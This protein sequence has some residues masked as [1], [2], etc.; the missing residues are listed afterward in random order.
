MGNHQSCLRFSLEESVWF[1][2]GQEVA[3]LVSISLDPDIAIQENDQY[4]TIRGSLELT[5][6]YK[7][8]DGEEEQEQQED[9]L[10]IPPKT[11]H[12]V[13]RNVEDNMEFS[14]RFPVDITIPKNRIEN[15]YDL[16]IVVE[17]FDYDIPE[18]HLLTLTADL[19]ITGLYG[20]Q[21]H[22]GREE[23]IPSGEYEGASEIDGSREEEDLPVFEYENKELDD[24]PEPV[25]LEEYHDSHHSLFS[26]EERIYGGQKEAEELQEDNQISLPFSAEARKEPRQEEECINAEKMAEE[27]LNLLEQRKEKKVEIQEPADEQQA[28]EEEKKNEKADVGE[29]ETKP[30]LPLAN[31]PETGSEEE[32][33]EKKPEQ[34]E[35]M[36][37]LKK[38]KQEEES[39]SSSEEDVQQEAAKK[40]SKKK[41]LSIA[42]FLAR[43]EEAEIAKIRVCIVQHGDTV[44]GLADRYEVSIQHLLRA[45]HIVIDQD[46]VE[47]QVLYIPAEMAPKQQ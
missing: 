5:G 8:A 34:E 45:N 20:D 2:R 37:N 22:G 40:Q 12:S 7:C 47:G 38:G 30:P 42:E 21:Q 24:I 9:D 29:K 31:S 33:K 27:E 43:K 3:E 1:Q 10:Y 36:L 11:V 32:E 46:I 19:S 6:E 13:A 16:N 26:L 14:H 18:K 4:V 35:K 15:I 23:V 41:S 28:A 25:P 17:A 44:Q 39:S